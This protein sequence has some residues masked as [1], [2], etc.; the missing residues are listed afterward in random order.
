VEAAAA[1]AEEVEPEVRARIRAGRAA[2]QESGVPVE[3]YRRI[4]LEEA[5]ALAC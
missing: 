5:L 4:N 3:T 1:R 2:L